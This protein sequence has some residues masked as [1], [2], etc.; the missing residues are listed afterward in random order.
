VFPDG[1]RLMKGSLVAVGLPQDI[2]ICVH[3][4]FQGTVFI[5][6]SDS[7]WLTAADFDQNGIATIYFEQAGNV[8]SGMCTQ[9]SLYAIIPSTQN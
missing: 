2:A 4:I 3:S 6:G 7:L 1:T 5:N 9:V 8:S